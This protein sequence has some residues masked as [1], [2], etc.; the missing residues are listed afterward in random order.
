MMDDLREILIQNGPLPGKWQLGIITRYHTRILEFE[1][2]ILL[3]LAVSL[4]H[5]SAT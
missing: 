5:L 4:A 2:D 3:R 1:L